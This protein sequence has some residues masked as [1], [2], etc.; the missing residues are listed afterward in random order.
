MADSILS[1]LQHEVLEGLF[2][3]GLG[4]RG[5]YLTGG[6]A[7]A[8]YYFKHRHSD[9]LDCFTRKGT[10][11][12]ED[13]DL[14]EEAFS[15]LGFAIFRETRSMR[16]ARYFVSRGE[17]ED[18]LKVEFCLDTGAM[19]APPRQEGVVVVDSLEDISVNKICAIL[20]RQPSEP[21]DFADLHFILKETSFTLDYLLTRA[22]EKD[23]A[24]EG[25]DGVL[26]FAVTLLE[27]G[28]LDHMPRMIR[29]MRPGEM[30]DFLRPQAEAVIL[31][32]RPDRGVTQ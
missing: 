32:L 16:Y 20:G 2:A 1:P 28:R 7:L 11:A 26:R 13:L 5:Y 19:L 10:L 30:A 25:E 8:E 27:A 17:R 22:R 15:R 4:E 31:R 24:F 29:P 23:V 21:K 18:R 6:T 12:G 9:D 3:Q 14:A